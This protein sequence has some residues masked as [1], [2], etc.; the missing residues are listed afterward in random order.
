MKAN[1][2][3]WLPYAQ[4]QTTLPPFEVQSTQ[5][6]KLLLKNGKTLIDGVASWWTACH[7]YNHPHIVKAIQEQAAV[8][9][10]VMMGGLVHPQATR[11]AERLANL[12]PGTLDYV[13]FSE[14]GSVA[15]EIA[16]K[17]A[18]QFWMNHNQPN[19]HRFICFEN[20][21]HGDTFFTMSVCD[22]IDGMH[23]L[24]QRVLPKQHCLSLPT[25]DTLLETFAT[26]LKKHAHECA[27][28]LIEPLVQGAGGMK[29]HSPQVLQAITSLC[30]QHNVLVIADEIFTGFLRT[31]TLFAIEQAKIIPDII[32]LSKALTGGTLPLAAT[33]ATKPIYDAFLSNDQSKALMHGTTFMGNALGCAAA[34]ASLDLFESEP[35]LK[36]VHAIQTMLCEAFSN[37]EDVPGVTAVRV[38]GA[39][40]AIELA[41][42]LTPSEM[43]RFKEQCV[44]D[45]IWCRPIQNVVYTTPALTIEPAQLSYLTQSIVKQVLAWS[46]LFCHA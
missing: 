1:A 10:H 38:K 26:W 32:C 13:F 19:K 17:M 25:T 21:Y 31:G 12:L 16:M 18:L 3:V 11:L 39:I 23:R 27:A 46:T 6:S 37:L 36:Q 9:P 7:G 30:Q 43:N 33:I 15:V 34:N 14:S 20:G 40:G 4:M 29:M 45:G 2:T 28:L 24:F 22:P 42:A 5:G 35:R 8:L 44:N 41:R